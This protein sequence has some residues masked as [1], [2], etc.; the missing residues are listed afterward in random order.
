MSST[1]PEFSDRFLKRPG[2]GD[3][4]WI[5][6]DEVDST[7]S[8]AKCVLRRA[9]DSPPFSLVAWRQTEGR[10]RGENAWLSP[11]GGGIYATF[12]P[13]PIERRD[14]QRLPLLVAVA[15]AEELAVSTGCVI[16]LKWP[17]DLLIKR[18]KVGGILVEA[19][20]AGRE[21][22]TVVGFGVNYRSREAVAELPHAVALQDVAGDL[23]TMDDLAHRLLTRLAT[24][25]AGGSTLDQV[26]ERYRRLCVHRSGEPLRCR[27]P[28]GGLVVGQYAG[29]NESG[30]LIL[31]TGSEKQEVVTGVLEESA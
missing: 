5:L 21:V 4:N 3:L 8:F 22:Q 24:E 14:L 2:D 10:G 28:G 26:T 13:A 6:L 7:N 16:G 17:N 27:L 19:V 31:E 23:P 29:I 30:C 11:A 18:G 20:T 25:L 9:A 12:V 15:L 1:F